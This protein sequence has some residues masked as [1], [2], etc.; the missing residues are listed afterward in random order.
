VKEGEKLE[1]WTLGPRLTAGGW[2][3]SI[4]PMLD[5]NLEE[6]ENGGIK[7]FSAMPM[8]HQSLQ[9]GLRIFFTGRIELCLEVSEQ[10]VNGIRH[11]HAGGGILKP[12]NSLRLS[13][14]VSEAASW[15][16]KVRFSHTPCPGKRQSQRST[17]HYTYLRRLIS[18]HARTTRG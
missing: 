2:A 7:G 12:A 8:A 15:A 4:R 13:R 16:P 5:H 1:D 3:R 17:L 6:M 18:I 9:D 11:A 10:I 14:R